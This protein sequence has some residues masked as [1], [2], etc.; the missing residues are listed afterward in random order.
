MCQVCNVTADLI[1][2]LQESDDCLDGYIKH[3]L[4]TEEHTEDIDEI[5]RRRAV[6]LLSAV[7]N[8]CARAQCRT[9]RHVNYLGVHLGRSNLC[10]EH[11]CREGAF[12]SLPRWNPEAS[13]AMISKKISQIRRI[14]CE[15]KNREDCRGCV[16]YEEELSQV[17]SHFCCKCGVLGPVPG[18]ES[19]RMTCIGVNVLEEPLWRCSSCISDSE[20]FDEIKTKESHCLKST[21]IL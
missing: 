3:F 17:L 21:R 8:L 5:Y 12:L 10:L 19:S 11:Y 18:D 1:P 6:F 16:S 14:I 20:D 7:L 4:P 9:R 2:H 13:A 15:K